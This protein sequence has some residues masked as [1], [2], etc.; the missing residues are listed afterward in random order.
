MEFNSNSN[1]EY[2]LDNIPLELIDSEKDL[3][4]ITCNN[5]NWVE[6]IKT[7]IKDANILIAWITRNIIS[8]DRTVM[9]NIYKT[10]IRP[11]LEYCVQ[12]W[13]PAAAHGNWS[14]ILEL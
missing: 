4:L 3:G 10:L 6:H 14:I 7:S 12:I 9:L 13:N 2:C 1:I 8:K 5:L 11:K